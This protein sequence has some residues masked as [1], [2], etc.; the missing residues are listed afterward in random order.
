MRTEKR[1]KLRRGEGPWWLP[2]LQRVASD[3]VSQKFRTMQ[4][5]KGSDLG[6]MFHGVFFSH[7]SQREFASEAPGA[8][9]T[10]SFCG[11]NLGVRN[12]RLC[13]ASEMNPFQPYNRFARF[14]PLREGRGG[15]ISEF[16]GDCV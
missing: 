16:G 5:L 7:A 13:L 3:T 14:K 10:R 2:L 4:G 9:I 12:A 6:P 11:Q 1:A 8:R 15:V